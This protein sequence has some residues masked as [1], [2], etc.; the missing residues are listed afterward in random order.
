MVKQILKKQ[1]TFEKIDFLILHIFS[2]TLKYRNVT[3]KTERW[4]FGTLFHSSKINKIAIFAK[5]HC[6][7]W[8]KHINLKSQHGCKENG[9]NSVFEKFFDLAK[10]F[11]R[12]VAKDAWLKLFFRVSSQAGWSVLKLHTG[13]KTNLLSVNY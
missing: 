5:V 9:I 2:H 3:V 1:W 12:T 10:L 11:R 6:F 13:A 8:A 4:R 7:L